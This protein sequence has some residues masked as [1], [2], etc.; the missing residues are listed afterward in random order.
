MCP[1]N[2]INSLNKKIIPENAGLNTPIGSAQH[3]A[4]QYIFVE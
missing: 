1:P 3:I 2:H 4:S